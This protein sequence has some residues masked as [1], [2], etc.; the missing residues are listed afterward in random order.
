MIIA[1]MYETVIEVEISGRTIKEF[2]ADTTRFREAIPVS[3][4]EFHSDRKTWIVKHPEKYKD[5][6]FIKAAL[7]NRER[8]L[9]LF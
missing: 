9:S 3:D 2:N 4:R 1:I 5:I 6:D 8:Q 7:A